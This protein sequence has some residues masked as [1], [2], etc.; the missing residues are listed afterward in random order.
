MSF[1]YHK[2]KEG[3]S[4]DSFWT[5][6][7]DLFLGLSTIFLLLY[8]ISSLR[9]GTDAIRSQVE[10]Q[11][12]S[13][14]LDEMRN[15]LKMYESVKNDYLNNAPK[16]EAQ[17]YQELMDKLTL[18]Q[19]DAKSEKDKLIQQA[20]EN[21]QK[22]KALNK[23]QQMIRNI[24][25]ANKMA[26]AKIIHRDDLI[27]DQDDEISNKESEIGDLQK[28]IQGKKQ[29]IAE[30][31][32]KIAETN[33]ALDKK[34]SELKYSLKMNKITRKRYQERMAQVQAEGDE[35]ISKLEDANE[36]Y[37]SQLKAKAD[38]LNQTQAAL[39][40]TQNSLS[41]TQ[42][43]L[44]QKEGEA[45]GLYD[46]LQQ[47]SADEQAKIQG[48]QAGFASE[49]ARDKANFE[50]E[51]GKQRLGAAERERREGAF[52][53]A[54]AAKERDMNGKLAALNGQ[55]H[56]TE[57]QLAK[58]KA[59]IE[60][61]KSVADEIK[62]GFAQAGVKAD[63]DMETGDVVLDFGQAYFDS[64]SDHL[65]SEMK[66]VLEKAMPI[67]SHSLFENPKLAGK[68]SAVEVI[69]FAS[70]TYQGRFIDPKSSK[71]EDKEAIK[72]NMD[73]SYRRAKSIFG[74]VL[75]DQSMHFNHQK[76]LVSLMKVSGRSFLEVMKVNN[77]NVASAAEFCK[78]NDCKKAQRVIVRFSMDGKK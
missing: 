75:D 17:E 6:Y 28:D 4:N 77:R 22:G 3:S 74:Y 49:K 34:M 8:V 30:G 21:D 32:R 44:S 42:N 72:Y 11:K 69:G 36:Q 9:T 52:R 63:V 37:N 16:D 66:N 33:D 41:Q 18:L 67:Y 1:N 20:L 47:A 24:L 73:L 40:Q 25:N 59:E 71:P 5:S 29:L 53:A 13:M 64:D 26:K 7:S 27:K 39:T 46:K 23:Y 10:N 45:K 61:R 50:K 58:A 68:I 31:E 15:Q 65:K 57:G 19:E 35:K 56:D 38:Q 60:A 54:A 62:K 12:L 70:P 43:A 78:V 51:L 48:I 55:L 14:Q 76:D 2:N